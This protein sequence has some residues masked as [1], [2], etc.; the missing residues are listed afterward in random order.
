MKKI[1][2][3]EICHA[4]SGDKGFHANIGLIVYDR[5]HYE[6]VRNQVTAARVGRFFKD[7]VRGDVKR[8]ELPRM[9]ALNF[10]L[11]DSL[12]GGATRTLTLDSYGKVLS[13]ALLSLEIEV[14]DDC[15]FSSPC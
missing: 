11:Y 8:Y 2:L 1:Q 9:G 14:P 15:I 13:S 3:R 12:D 4:R 6:L 5:Q 7:S 10:V